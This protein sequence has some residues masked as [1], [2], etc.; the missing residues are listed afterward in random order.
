MSAPARINQEIE[1]L[2]A[3][4]V[5]LVVYDHLPALFHWGPF[6]PPTYGADPDV[7]R[8][9]RIF[10]GW[11][12]VDLFFCISGYVISLSFVELFDRLKAEGR[13]WTATKAFWIRRAFRILPSAWLW[14]AVMIACSAWFNQ[15][16]TF[17][18]LEQNLRAVLPVLLYYANFASV[19]GGLVPNGIY[20]SL[21][22]EEQFYFA[23]PLFLA[24]VVAPWRWKVLLVLIGAQFFLKRASIDT[25]VW[26]VRLD[27][28]MWGC[29]IHQFSRTAVYAS[30]D[31]AF[32]RDW[33]G[34]MFVAALLLA[35]LGV[36]P[37]HFPWPSRHVALIALV[38]AAL[39]L[40]ASYQ[41]GYLLPANAMLRKA[42][43]WTG[44]RSFAIY[45]VHVP[46]FFMAYEVVFRFAGEAL[47]PAYRPVLAAIGLPLM[48][49]L[50]EFNYRLVE[51]PLRRRGAAIAERMTARTDA[52]PPAAS[53][54][55]S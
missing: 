10:A 50:A 21:S 38:S 33:R 13:G 8:A 36:V 5:L 53:A 41:R 28:I 32:L 1:C 23:Y 25:I 47:T 45:L 55:A 40:L 30:W 31:P 43:V 46:A 24:A 49:L 42:L 39:V 4:A 11:T 29:I 51:T 3:V 44:S 14:L 54:A 9:L 15:S 20:W 37:N 34:R 22:L 6:V 7:I 2:R 26:H 48:C 27:A 35:L 19:G 17:M 52:R 12:G 18:T 16:G